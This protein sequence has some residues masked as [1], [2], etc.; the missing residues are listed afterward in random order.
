MPLNSDS[1]PAQPAPAP[2]HVPRLFPLAMLVCAALVLLVPVA[3]AA[4]YKW[5][6]DQGVVH[7]TDKM[8]PEAINKGSVEL[9]KQGIPVRKND[10]A[11]TPEQRRAR[12]MEDERIR[13]ATRA[14][15]ESQRKDRALLQT[16][17]TESEIDLA[18]KRALGTIDGQVQS[19]QAYTATLAKRKQ[20]VQTRAAAF[21]DKPL[22]QALERELNSVNEELEK[23]AELIAAK[24]KEIS[25][26]NARYDADKIRWQE[27]AAL[28]P[29]TANAA[30]ASA[31]AAV[32]PAINKK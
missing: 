2:R 9:N 1:F 11:L 5:I 21:A 12:E 24:R 29:A 14:R 18:R 7:Y 20:E 6:D 3:G 30:P 17:T 13:Q 16:Y 28:T 4:T 8:P 15:E 27:L 32:V 25:V 22:P 19:A 26:V 31:P 10:P 23:Q